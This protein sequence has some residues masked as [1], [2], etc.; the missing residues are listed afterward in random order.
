LRKEVTSV[1]I[2]QKG[3]TWYVD[4]YVGQGKNKR[5][6][7][8]AVG[9]RKRDALARF[10]KIQ[11]A[12]KENR[13]FDVRKDFNFTFDE[14]VEKYVE[15]FR[16]QRYFKNKI[17]YLEVYREYFSGKLLAGI[18]PLGLETFK[19]KRLDTPLSFGRPRSP[20]TVNHELSTL[21]HMLSKAVEWE[22]LE[23][24]PFKKVKA[25]RLFDKLNN[26]RLRYLS[27]EEIGRLLYY[28]NGHLKAIVLTALHT[29]M[30]KGEILNLKWQDIRDGLIYLQKTKTNEPRQ[31][32]V[33][34]QLADALQALPRN[35]KSDYV[36]CHAKNGK[37]YVEL[38]KSFQRALGRAGIHDFR[39][40][41]LRHTFASHLVMKG[42][43]LKA[44][45][46]LLGHKDIKMT[47]RYAHLS[48]DHKRSAIRLLDGFA[49]QPSN[50]LL[51]ESPKYGHFL[52]TQEK[53]ATSKSL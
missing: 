11:A 35:I 45:Q 33:S 23:E 12:K 16:A 26:K 53:K 30:R 13:L 8:E 46:E 52:D 4:Y 41:D 1:G 38:K 42:A 20:T 6:V 24:S 51:T 9:P 47:M 40:H 22:M 18:T 43:S 34:E 32:P 44:V 28:C 27:E 25:S 7:R 29:G 5:R 10:G 31:I 14:L 3:D 49:G 36:F 48:Q 17:H 50:N 39:F 19:N 37:P 2:Y 15:N 21:R